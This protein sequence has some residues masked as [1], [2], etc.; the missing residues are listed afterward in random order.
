MIANAF[1]TLTLDQLRRYVR[2]EYRNLLVWLPFLRLRARALKSIF[3]PGQE[4]WDQSQMPAP[5]IINLPFRSERLSRVKSQLSR[6]G[7]EDFVVHPAVHGREAF[8]LPADMSGKRGCAASH[9]EVLRQHADS[10]SP[11]FVMEDDID[12]VV[13]AE[14]LQATILHFLRNK[15]M[16]VLCLHSWSARTRR[17]DDTVS[18]ATDVTS[19]AAYLVK[20]RAI[21][22]LQRDFE[23]SAKILARGRN[24]PID[25]A[26]WRSQR[27]NLVFVVPNQQVATQVGGHSDISE[28]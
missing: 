27:W 8:P 7:V 17:A 24:V 25:H 28:R 3:S 16:D 23:R 4:S 26:W 9:I 19:T 15:A 10:R 6:V 11:I 14:E 12:F 1:K 18:L 5:F 20:P 2:H 21:R 13:G 22:Y